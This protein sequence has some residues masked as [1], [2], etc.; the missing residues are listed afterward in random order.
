MYAAVYE[1]ARAFHKVG[2]L[3]R[4][5]VEH[6][7]TARAGDRFAHVESKA[8]HKIRSKRERFRRFRERM[9]GKKTDPGVGAKHDTSFH[10]DYSLG[11]AHIT[12]A[13]ECP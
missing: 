3:G 10:D 5:P 6:Q 1:K 11:G 2:E 8:R 13:F 7:I 4:G 9:R 12:L